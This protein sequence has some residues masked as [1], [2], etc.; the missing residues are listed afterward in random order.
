MS[1]TVVS[2]YYPIQSKFPPEQ[3]L[4]WIRLFWPH[5]EAN[6]VFFTSPQMTDTVRGIL[7]G[8][9][10]KTCLV[11]IPFAELTAFRSLH[12]QVW[13][14]TWESD[15]E[16]GRHTPELYG[17]WYEKKEFVRRAIEMNPFSSEKFVWCDAGIC[18]TAE[19]VGVLRRFPLPEMVPSGKMLMLSIDPF[20]QEDLE[21]DVWGIPGMFG[22]RATL[23]GGILAS[24][25][26]GWRAWAAAYDRMLM[27]YWLSGRFIGK[28][29]NIMASVALEHPELCVVTFAPP[30]MN[31][32][33]KWF[34]LLFYLSA[35]KLTS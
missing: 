6:L 34:Y 27:R 15:P 20:R 24:D 25:T 32:V 31:T 35:V 7:E 21:R 29:Q 26:E 2:A 30:V 16:K 1:V 19:W 13:M 17:L 18:R 4:D 11:T 33:T 22:E 12:P 3:Y 9:P 23:G 8:R 10:G 5:N 14:K 28:D